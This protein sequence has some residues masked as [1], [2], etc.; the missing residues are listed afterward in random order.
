M[1]QPVVI[2]DPAISTFGFVLSWQ[3]LEGHPNW[4][5]TNLADFPTVAGDVSNVNPS[6]TPQAFALSLADLTRLSTPEGPFPNL[7]E[8][9]GVPTSWWWTRTP[10]NSVA[11]YIVRPNGGIYLHTM[12]SDYGETGANGGVRPAIIVHQ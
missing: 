8:R 11:S 6:G 12:T 2:P 9:R 1:V 5:P 7:R 10:G 4:I 3:S